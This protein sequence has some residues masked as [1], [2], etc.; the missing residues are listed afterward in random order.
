M[1]AGKRP[2]RAS[3]RLPLAP[4][5]ASCSQQRLRILQVFT[6]CC[7]RLILLGDS[8]EVPRFFFFGGLPV[9]EIERKPLFF[10]EHARTLLTAELRC[11]EERRFAVA[12]SDSSR[13]HGIA[14]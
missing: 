1:S 6:Q 2:F 10:P 4:K 14:L 9:G 5:L 13:R 8:H 7:C 12:Y 3:K 11:D